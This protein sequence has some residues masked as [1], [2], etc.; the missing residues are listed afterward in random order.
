MLSRPASIFNSFIS[1]R[2]H[3]EVSMHSWRRALIGQ[4]VLVEGTRMGFYNNCINFSS[5]MR[6]SKG[7]YTEDPYSFYN[8]IFSVTEM[9]HLQRYH[10]L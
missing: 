9:L 7:K 6:H 2:S 3:Q 1:A 5:L 10:M 8:G 4:N